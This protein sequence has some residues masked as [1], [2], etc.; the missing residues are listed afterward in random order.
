LSNFKKTVGRAVFN[1]NT[2][3]VGLDAV[4][5]GYPKPDGL[6]ISWSPPDR[7]IAARATRK[8]AVEAVLVHVSEAL[9]QYVAALSKLSQFTD[10][11]KNW[12]R[13]Q[14]PTKLEKEKGTKKRDVSNAEKFVDVAS[15]L[16]G[17]KEYRVSGAALLI[18]WRNRVVHPNS[19]AQLKPIQKQLLQK[20]EKIISEEY[21][22]LS[23]DCLLCHFHEKRPT[24]KDISSLIAMT[25]KLAHRMDEK[26]YQS[27]EKCDVIAWLDHYEISE[28]IEKVKRESKPEK[29]EE[30]IKRVFNT[31]APKLKDHYFEFRL[32]G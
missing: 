24:L 29:V 12:D 5:N 20:N 10:L 13:I 7:K 19:N 15:Q 23:V 6:D 28:I 26:I 17:E 1:L 8:F 32:L 3:V 25:I 11:R 16:I 14:N 31:H 2:I 30:S 27:F 4:E 22:N 18:H 21:S 9:S